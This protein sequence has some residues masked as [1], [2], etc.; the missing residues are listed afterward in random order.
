MVPCSR[1]FTR[2]KRARPSTI[3]TLKDRNH[4][5]RGLWPE[6]NQKEPRIEHGR[7]TDLRR[8][9]LTGANRENR[10]ECRFSVFSVISCSFVVHSF[11]RSAWG[12]AL[13]KLRFAISQPEITHAAGQ[14]HR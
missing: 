12:R 6:P 14:V 2:R 10:G 11:P 8:K 9:L 13:S 5:Q 7:N 3:G 1:D 4:T